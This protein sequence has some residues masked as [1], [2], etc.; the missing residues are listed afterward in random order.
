MPRSYSRTERVGQLIQTAIAK[1]MQDYFQD[2]P[3]SFVT[4][5]GVDVSPD[6]SVAKVFVSVLPD[7]PTFVADVLR[8]LKLQ[9]KRMRYELAHEINLR[10]MP[11]IR[12]SF[13]ES[14]RA[15]S[16]MSSVL[17]KLQDSDA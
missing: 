17:N 10:S 7:E 15:G 11:Q 6:Y 13:D 2:E 14:V 1:L 12:F 8:R 9:S 5:T 16:H 4:V 3:G